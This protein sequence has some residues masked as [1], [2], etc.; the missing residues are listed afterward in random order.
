MSVKKPKAEK[1]NANENRVHPHGTAG[2]AIAATTH[3]AV[4]AKSLHIPKGLRRGKR[5]SQ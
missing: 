4:G 5:A 1:T 3:E 2:H